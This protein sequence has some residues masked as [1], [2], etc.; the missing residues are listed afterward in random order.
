MKIAHFEKRLISYFIDLV[1]TY[2]I[3]LAM[4]YSFLINYEIMRRFGVI[5]CLLT[6]GSLIYL[7]FNTFITKVTNGYTVGNII[8]NIKVVNEQDSKIS[9]KNSF[10][11][12]L[13]LCFPLCSIINA[14][15]MLFIH[16]QISIF[17]KLSSTK[18]ISNNQF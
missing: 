17:D 18:T 3:C 13:F 4:Y 9:W 7:L 15:Y 5:F 12:Y 6:I 1:I 10:L 2:G 14:F 8:M 11:K 16:T